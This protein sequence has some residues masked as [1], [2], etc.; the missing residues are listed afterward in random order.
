[1]VCLVLLVALAV[2]HRQHLALLLAART[3]YA[4]LTDVTGLTTGD[5]VDIA[6]VPVGQVTGI[7][8]QR[9]HALVG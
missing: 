9:G 6:G 2:K 5:P 4:Q 1:M 8:V 3:Y 7:T